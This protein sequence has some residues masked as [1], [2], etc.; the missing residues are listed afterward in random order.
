MERL[1]VPTI[2]SDSSHRDYFSL[3]FGITSDPT[4][5]KSTT[6]LFEV[7]VWYNFEKEVVD[8]HDSD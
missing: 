4:V 1:D 6:G 2:I 7:R 8:F 3:T 5:H